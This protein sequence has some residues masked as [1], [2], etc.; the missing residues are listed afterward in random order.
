M[1]IVVIIIDSD[2]P[3]TENY[4]ECR[5]YWRKYMN[6]FDNIKCYFIRYTNNI[7]T[8]IYIDNNTNT[9]Y[10]KGEE[11]FIPGI[12]NKTLDAMN[13]LLNEDFDFLLRTNLS[14]VWDFYKLQDEL[15]KTPKHNLVKAVIGNYH[16]TNFPSG[17]GYILSK[18]MT[19]LLVDN[20]DKFNKEV[21]VYDDV[22]TGFVLK[23]LNISIKKGDRTD[24]TR[25][26]SYEEVRLSENAYHYRP[27]FEKG[28]QDWMVANRLINLIYGI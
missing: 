23:E 6:L 22:L 13:Y 19:K 2:G 10:I 15:V 18:D 11:S 7:Q 16:G 27:V 21:N 24:F 20:R 4:Q 12:M 9:M 14:S 17:A 26:T 5:K 28:P 3:H 25:P 8:P 1:K